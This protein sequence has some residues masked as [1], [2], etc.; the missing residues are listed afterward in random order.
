MPPKTKH[1]P[2]KKQ[3]IPEDFKLSDDVPASVNLN[4]EQKLSGKNIVFECPLCRGKLQMRNE[5]ETNPKETKCRCSPCNV[6]SKSARV[7]KQ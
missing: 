6:V 3:P 1:N 2:I 4:E 5:I 7:I